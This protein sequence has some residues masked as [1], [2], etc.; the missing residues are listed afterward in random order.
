MNNNLQ[1]YFPIIK[2]RSEI[3]EFIKKNQRLNRIFI[4]WKPEQQ[5]EFLDFCSGARGVKILYD[6]FFK[7]VF[8]PEYSPERLNRLLSILLGMKVSI[9]KVLPLDST[10]M[11]DETSLVEMDIVVQTEDGTIIN[12]EVQKIG[13]LFPGQRCA[14]YSSDLLLRQYKRLRDSYTGNTRKFKYKEIMPVY[15]I[16]F[17]ERSPSCFNDFPNTYIHN[18][19]QCSYTGLELELLQKYTFISLDIFKKLRHNK[20]IDNELDAWLTFLS[21]DDVED[22]I[23]LIENYPEFKPL[24]DTVYGLCQNIEEVMG[25]FSK[26]LFELDR[27]TAE[28]MVDEFGK[29]IEQQKI[30]LAEKDSIIA[31]KDALIAKLMSENITK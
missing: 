6:S 15:T 10:R 31:E 7:E 30:Q 14:C 26:E 3:F 4:R 23:Q 28:F 8:N 25:M 24:Y 11:G 5:D 19:K 16:V 1:L 2:N 9:I 27:N 21:S 22:I 13:Y 29:T 12:V 20:P 17:F 18:F